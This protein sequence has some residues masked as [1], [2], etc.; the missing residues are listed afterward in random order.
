[1]HP[2]WIKV[3]FSS[4]QIKLNN[5]TKQQNQ[6]Q[7]NFIKNDDFGHDFWKDVLSHEF[8]HDAKPKKAID[9]PLA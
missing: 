6:K 4:K 9:K 8:W 5:E 1:M 7:Y 3:S 2:S